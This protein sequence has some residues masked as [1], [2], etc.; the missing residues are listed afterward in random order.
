MPKKIELKKDTS[1]TL[2]KKHL[3][4]SNMSTRKLYEGEHKV[5]L[6]INGLIYKENTFTLRR[7]EDTL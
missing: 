2:Q 4:K 5:E 3:F 6:Q 1:I 7:S